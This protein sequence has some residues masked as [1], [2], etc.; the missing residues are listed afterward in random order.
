MPRVDIQQIHE[1]KRNGNNEERIFIHHCQ[2]IRKKD[3]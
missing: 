1:T 2:S 3:M